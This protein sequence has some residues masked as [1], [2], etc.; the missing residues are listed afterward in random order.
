MR[1]R[2]RP[3]APLART[4]LA[5][6]LAAA[7]GDGG[8]VVEPVPLRLEV[9]GRLE[10]GA[11]VH[12]KVRRGGAALPPGGAGLAFAP[13]AA[14]RALGGDSVRLLAAGALTV[15]AEAD[16][17]RATRTVQ[18]ALPPLLVFDRVVAGNRDLWRVALDGGDLARLTT[19]PAEDRD[20]TV[21]A[22][23]VVFSSLRA[24]DSFEL[25]SMPLEGGAATRLTTTAGDES[26][27]ALSPDGQRLAYVRDDGMDELWLAAGDAR[28]AVRA[29][30]GGGF[31]LE[32]APAWA[33]DGGRL[34][35]ASSAAGT[36]D[37]YAL[38]PG[39]APER[40]VGGDAAETD[41]AFSPDGRWLAFASTRDGGGVGRLYLLELATGQVTGLT[42][43]GSGS[44]PAWTPDGRL[45]FV[46]TDAAGGRLRWLEPAAP[47]VVHEIPTGGGSARGPAVVP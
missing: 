38:V 47:A 42:P 17:E 2:S 46:A 44:Q 21:A 12:V 13:A 31:A 37:V 9:E 36:L 7:C 43:T 11:V 18:V 14:A 22:G 5:A 28:G 8:G 25:F 20:A 40:L 4:L 1:H 23:R 35:F 10:R 33:A 41:P 26:S 29:T 27:P 32:L 34:A 24:G 45:V 6:L 3:S 30:A 19:D 15:S 39:G 16:G